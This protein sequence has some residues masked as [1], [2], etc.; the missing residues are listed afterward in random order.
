MTTASRPPT[1]TPST[2]AERAVSGPNVFADFGNQQFHSATTND[3]D[4]PVFAAPDPNAEPVDTL[5]PRTEYLLP[6]TLLAFNSYADWVQ[7]YLPTRPNSSTG[8]VRTTD[9]KMSAQPLAWAV[10]VDLA[11]Y[12]VTVLKNGAV[13]YEADA[14]I[15]SP[16]YPTPTGIFYVTDPLD[17]RNQPGTGYGAFAIGLSGPLRRAHRLRRRRRP[18]RDP[19]H[20]QP[21][22]HRAGDLARVR[23]PQ[24]RRHHAAVD[25]AARH[26]RLHHLSR[27][28]RRVTR[29]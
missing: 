9:V 6:R 27:R 25:V 7:V 4:I 16:E 22:R 2:E 28:R 26:A 8:W 20:R 5:S 21:G 24:Q 19:R 12:K 13:D 1:P 17:L 3:A 14:A 29:R 23:A 10:K 11:N 15:G 18:D